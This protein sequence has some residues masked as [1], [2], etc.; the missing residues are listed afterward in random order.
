MNNEREPVFSRESISQA[1]HQYLTVDQRYTEKHTL[2]FQLLSQANELE[3]ERKLCEMTLIRLM[4]A[5][6]LTQIIEENLML[7]LQVVDEEVVIH[8][9]DEIPKRFTATQT[10]SE[11]DMK[12]IYQALQKGETIPGAHLEQLQVIN[13]KKTA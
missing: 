12:S 5:K 9:E 7:S 13:V 2:A 1:I 11:L 6:E 3:R 8:G 4:Q 10:I